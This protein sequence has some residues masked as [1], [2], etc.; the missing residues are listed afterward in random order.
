M[1]AVSSS[2]CPVEQASHAS[3]RRWFQIG[4]FAR[5]S[6]KRW[7]RRN[8]SVIEFCHTRMNSV[9]HTAGRGALQ[10]RLDSYWGQTVHNVQRLLRRPP[11]LTAWPGKEEWRQRG[12]FFTFGDVYGGSPIPVEYLRCSRWRFLK[13]KR[14]L[15]DVASLY[16][17]WRTALATKIAAVL[18]VLGRAVADS[19]RLMQKN[20]PF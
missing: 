7:A 11:A 12:S 2:R 4:A 18:S 14:H 15:A 19:E 13:G 17:N 8:G 3:E 5:G 1:N 16:T 6:T 9:S 10:I 20:G